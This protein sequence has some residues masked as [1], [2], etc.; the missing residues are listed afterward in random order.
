MGNLTGKVY[1][2]SLD[3]SQVFHQ[4]PV[5]ANSIPK[6]AF[7]T[8]DGHYEY[9]RMPFG[10]V[11]APSV[12]QR[13]INEALG[14]L[15]FGK[16]LVYMDDL[17]LPSSTID[18]GLEPLEEVLRLLNLQKCEFLHIKIV[19]LGHEVS[20]AG[21]SPGALK[22]DAVKNS[23]QP[24]NVHEIRQFLGIAGYFRKFIKG[25]ATIALPL[26]TLTRK[27]VVWSWG[28]KEEERSTKLNPR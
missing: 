13:L 8:P 3:Y 9:L 20:A 6:T 19:Y 22:T 17:L 1:F 7:I 26:T 15:R 28:E 4:I 14:N 25:F 24:S 16:V 12:F 2:T 10:L 5:E 21:I 11:N 27:N 23:K 18:E